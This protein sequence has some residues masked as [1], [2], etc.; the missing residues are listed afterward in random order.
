MIPNLQKNNHQ[1][2]RGFPLFCFKGDFNGETGLI[3]GE[4]PNLVDLLFDE[5]SNR[6]T[7]GDEPFFLIRWG[8][9]WAFFKQ[10]F[11]RILFFNATLRLLILFGFFT[12]LPVSNF[13]SCT[14][15]NFCEVPLDIIVCLTKFFDCSTKS[16]VNVWQR[17]AKFE[18]LDIFLGFSDRLVLLRLVWLPLLVDVPCKLSSAFVEG[19]VRFF[20]K[21]AFFRKLVV[22]V[23]LMTNFLIGETGVL[24]GSSVFT[25]KQ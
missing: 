14:C 11:F 22:F 24:F 15:W 12:K 17:N 3:I 9:F 13:K 10:T 20:T 8:V 23:S 5:K 6:W 25:W 1:I 2:H 7:T 19:G 16:G 21:Q 18:F 4:A